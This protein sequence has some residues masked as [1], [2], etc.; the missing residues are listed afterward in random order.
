MLSLGSDGCVL[1]FLWL[2]ARVGVG[3]RGTHWC[4]FDTAAAAIVL[5]FVLLPQSKLQ[6]TRFCWS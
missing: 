3:A 6:W 2:W 5:C 4:S 1:V